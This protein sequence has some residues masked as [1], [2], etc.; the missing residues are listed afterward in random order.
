[1]FSKG[2]PRKTPRI[3]K[4]TRLFTNLSGGESANLWFGL[5][6]RVSFLMRCH[7]GLV[8]YELDLLDTSGAM[9]SEAQG[10]VA[11][12]ASKNV[13]N[14]STNP[15]IRG[16]HGG[17]GKKGGGKKGGGKPHERHPSQKGGFGSPPCTVRSPAPSSASALFLYKKSATKQTR[18]SSGGVQKVSGERVLSLSSPHTF[19]L[20]TGKYGCTEV[21]VY[22]AECGETTWER[23]LKNWELQIP[24]F[25]EFWG[26][27]HVLGLVPASVPHTLGYACTF[28]APPISRPNLSPQH[29]NLGQ[30]DTKVANA[31]TCYR[32][33]DPPQKWAQKSIKMSKK[34][35]FGELNGPKRDFLDILIDFWAHFSGGVENGIFS[36]FKMHFWG[37]GVPGLCSRSGR[38]QH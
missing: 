3:Q 36:D 31:L 29:L 38:L 4:S 9:G 26:G 15:V 11:R 34:S 23:S 37:F 21:R 13:Q 25:E 12:I 19:C 5:H 20:D 16:R 10:S 24:C 35:L 1:M 7:G 8:C 33:F 30:Q 18:S 17:G 27:E 28:Y 14:L 2:H 6:G 32:S 22:P